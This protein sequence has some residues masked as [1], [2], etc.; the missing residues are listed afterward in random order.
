MIAKTEELTMT[1]NDPESG[2][3]AS[4]VA[5]AEVDRAPDR[6][7]GLTASVGVDRGVN[8]EEPSG[9]R[10]ITKRQRKNAPDLI[11]QQQ[12][13]NHKM[14]MSIMRRRRN[15]KR[16]AYETESRCNSKTRRR[17]ERIEI[18]TEMSRS[19]RRHL[20]AGR[21]NPS[22]QS[23]P[24]RPRIGSVGMFRSMKETLLT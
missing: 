5:G 24:Q 1:D 2:N 12:E 7:V 8:L 21:S 15:G 11:V 9:D 10:K 22:L 19:L 13:Q 6:T 16:S 23:P 14:Q 3:V 4:R 20:V 17:S 18:L